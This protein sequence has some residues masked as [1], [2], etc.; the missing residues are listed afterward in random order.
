M[1]WQGY[2]GKGD[3]EGEEDR[4]VEDLRLELK[5]QKERL[6]YLEKQ[7]TECHKVLDAHG[8]Q[9][10]DERIDTRIRRAFTGRDDLL[11]YLHEQLE[12]VAKKTGINLDEEDIYDVPQLLL[13]MYFSAI[14]K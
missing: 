8:F 3:I 12:D 14:N 4:R 10:N 6:E 1:G 2:D 7:I 9:R 13:K 11:G 5:R